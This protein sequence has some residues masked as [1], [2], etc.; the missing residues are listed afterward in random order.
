MVVQALSQY[1]MSVFKIP[2]SIC[3]TIEQKIA[4]FWWTTNEKQEGIH[5]KR[6][7]IL[8]TKK[9]KGGVGFKD[10]LSFNKAML[11]KQAWRLGQNS[12]SLWSSLFKGLYYLH[13]DFW[14]AA[15]GL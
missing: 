1:A 11:G 7:D 15:K 9:D 10:L 12:S 4:S 3:K 14:H 6:W 5:W 2:I 13:T 8:K